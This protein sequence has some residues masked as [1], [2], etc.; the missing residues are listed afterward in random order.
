MFPHITESQAFLPKRSTR[1]VGGF[2]NSDPRTFITN[3]YCV[4][5]HPSLA[6]IY[7]Y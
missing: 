1:K 7:V 2:N 6:K 5:L 4:N 3:Y